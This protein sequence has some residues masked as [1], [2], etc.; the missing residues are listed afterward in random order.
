M[1][2]L[3]ERIQAEIEET[4]GQNEITRGVFPSKRTTA[5]EAQL[6]T[7]GGQARQGERRSCVE[8][9]YLDIAGTSLQL[10]QLFYDRD[11]MATYISDAGDKFEWSWS[12]EDI[13]IEADIDL[14][15]T[16]KENLTREERFQRAVF[17][18]NML[19]PLPEADRAEIM[20]WTLREAGLDPDDTRKMVRT[21]EEVSAQQ[22]SETAAPN[23][24]AEG[25]QKSI[26]YG[27][28]YGGGPKR[29]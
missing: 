8:E 18:A 1:Y 3:Q 19:L 4:T 25:Q 2:N 23:V 22:M 16:P 9:W 12:K 21:Q 17:V 11:R 27:S 15:I 20:S 10:M 24:F 7:T 29:G 14:A 13:A 6:V 28:M 26:A 5:T